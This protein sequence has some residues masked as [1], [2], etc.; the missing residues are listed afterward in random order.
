MHLSIELYSATVSDLPRS[1][2]TEIVFIGNL[3][4]FDRQVDISFCQHGDSFKN[5]LASFCYLFLCQ[6]MIVY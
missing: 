6:N 1:K 2:I 4:M 3:E 5:S